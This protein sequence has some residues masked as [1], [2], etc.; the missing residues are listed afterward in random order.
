MMASLSQY[1][2]KIRQKVSTELNQFPPL[3]DQLQCDKDRLRSTRFM[4]AVQSV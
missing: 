1:L 2:V 4:S 3:I